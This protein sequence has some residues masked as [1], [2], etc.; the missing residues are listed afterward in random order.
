MVSIATILKFINGVYL[1]PVFDG[2]VPHS[3]VH[4][5][6]NTGGLDVYRFFFS[7]ALSFPLP[8][9]FDRLNFGI[10]SQHEG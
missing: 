10:G 6:W 8:Q 3:G 5:E 1:R 7:L 9:P 4:T 2:S